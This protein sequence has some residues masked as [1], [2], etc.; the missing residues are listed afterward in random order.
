MSPELPPKSVRELAA[1]YLRNRAEFYAAL[2][3]R[4]P[5][6]AQ[7][8]ALQ[9]AA[10]PLETD[11]RFTAVIADLPNETSDNDLLQALGLSSLLKKPGY[12]RAQ[13]STAISIMEALQRAQQIEETGLLLWEQLNNAY[14]I[15]SDA[16]AIEIQRHRDALTRL[17]RFEDSL[18]Y[19]RFPP[20]AE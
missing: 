18:R 16:F 3:P 20:L 9:T 17:L 10:T 13:G 19:H 1:N 6:A 8:T 7:R 4:I 14:P 5:D 15:F 11:A 2:L 12:G